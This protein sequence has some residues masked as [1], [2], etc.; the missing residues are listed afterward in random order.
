M[1]AGH[2]REL[3]A[4][5]LEFVI[6]YVVENWAARLAA[7]HGQWFWDYTAESSEHFDDARAE[8]CG[9]VEGVRAMLGAVN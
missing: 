3:E 5:E 8:L 7:L 1:T 4:L 9:D 6:S 2:T